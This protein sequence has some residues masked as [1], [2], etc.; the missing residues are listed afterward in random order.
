MCDKSSLRPALEQPPK[1]P[2]QIWEEKQ[3][4]EN[5]KEYMA[6]LKEHVR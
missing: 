5:E 3:E 6:F 2:E 1:T 4:R